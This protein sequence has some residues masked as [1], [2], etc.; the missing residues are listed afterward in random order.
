[1]A[2]NE[3]LLDIIGRHL[4]PVQDGLWTIESGP[5][6]RRFIDELSASTTETVVT[7]NPGNLAPG[8]S[9]SKGAVWDERSILRGIA[10]RTVVGSPRSFSTGDREYC[11]WLRSIGAEVR[12]NG[13]L[14]T[15]MIMVDDSIALLRSDPDDIA[16]AALVV[17]SPGVLAGCRSLFEATWRASRPLEDG[18]MAES[19][20][21]EVDQELLKL[22]A[23]GATDAQVARALDMSPRQVGR[24]IARLGNELGAVGRFALGV[25]AERRGWLA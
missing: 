16:S 24:R 10:H 23:A 17:T 15:R 3:K 12:W 4:I 11:A 6:I 5:T 19:N 22:L 9:M 25:A 2:V 1:M 13:S 18:F 14:S 8:E 20:R 21:D 7:M